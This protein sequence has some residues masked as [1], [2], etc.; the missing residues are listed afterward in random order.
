MRYYIR[1]TS[2]ND[3]ERPVSGLSDLAQAI[4]MELPARLF[5]GTC[6]E[7]VGDNTNLS[8][9]T[10]EVRPTLEV[11]QCPGID[12][13]C[14][15]DPISLEFAPNYRNALHR[16]QVIGT[17]LVK[18]QAEVWSGNKLDVQITK[19]PKDLHAAIL[20]SPPRFDAFVVIDPAEYEISRRIDFERLAK[21]IPC[22][23]PN[24]ATGEVH[25]VVESQGKSRSGYRAI[26]TGPMVNQWHD[27]VHDRPVVSGHVWYISKIETKDF[28]ELIDI[29]D[30]I[31]HANSG[32]LVWLST[33][34]IQA[35]QNRVPHRQAA[36]PLKFGAVSASE[37]KRM[38]KW[39][40]RERAHK[41]FI[42]GWI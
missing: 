10:H 36:T 19:L 22:S 26:A 34:E 17:R 37:G 4:D 40:I 13:E 27:I 42:A 15:G 39:I 21:K 41:H 29:L 28:T 8:P 2:D 38:G 25:H 11:F 14:A 35:V 32:A 24:L 1:V 5:A 31:F 12:M 3:V 6:D 33:T 18:H 9:R 30:W 20:Q 16:V 23:E 7:L